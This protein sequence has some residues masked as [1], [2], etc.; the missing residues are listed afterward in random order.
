M[1]GQEYR[2]D[3]SGTW[4]T[5]Q[6]T[7]GTD[8]K[9][10]YTYSDLDSGTKY[11]IETRT[12]AETTTENKF[13]S[14]PASVTVTTKTSAGA[15]PTVGAAD[16]TDTTITLPYDAAWEYSTDQQSW[17]DTHEFTGLTAATQ[18]TYYVR[19]AETETAEAS[20]IA[21]VT[22]YTAHATPTEG[23]GY[24]ISYRDETATATTGYEILNGESWT[25]EAVKIIPSSSFQVRHVAT[26]G[27]AP[28]SEPLTV[29]IAERPTAPT[30][31][32]HTD[33][34]LA[35][36]NDGTISGVTTAMEYK[37]STASEWTPCAGTTITH[38]APGT[39]QVRTAAT[40]AAFAGE[41]ASVTIEEVVEIQIDKSESSIE[42][43][44]EGVVLTATITGIEDVNKAENWIWES[45]NKDIVEVNR[46][47]PEASTTR[48]ADN[49]IE[50][51]ARVIPKG[52]GQAIITVIYDSPTYHGEK[53]YEITVKEKEE[54]EPEEPVTPDYPDYY[55]IYVEE[56]EG[57]TVETS[58]NVVREG[59]S[60]SFTVEVAEG[61]T[62]ED[63]VVKVKRSLF[64]YT[65]VIEP[66]EEGKER[67]RQV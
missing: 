47:T 13:A 67:G 34:T 52:V 48:S 3:S 22:V 5:L 35:G 17:S 7:T 61:Y 57:V 63:M 44:S 66:N 38:L 32:S 39:Y 56:C 9:T 41:A 59:N 46:L 10:V 25:T 15:A 43:G 49:P 4:S 36:M 29:Q 21:T 11:T 53:T 19:V 28:A 16:V 24:T 50:S 30:G 8:G 40:D 45:S 62:A 42:L 58:T 12:P 31:L 55:N 14:H 27:G 37:L 23:T 18:Y 33:E 2:L 60:M 54:E 64:G 51:T 20:E 1:S 6:G 26:E 65:D